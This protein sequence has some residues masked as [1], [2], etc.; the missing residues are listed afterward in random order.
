MNQILAMCVMARLIWSQCVQTWMRRSTEESS[1][2]PK[3]IKVNPV[4]AVE[5][6][7]AFSPRFGRIFYA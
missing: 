2:D 5:P 7:V 1:R 6:K 4:P 3:H